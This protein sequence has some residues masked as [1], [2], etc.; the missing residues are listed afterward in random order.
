[1]PDAA[2][3]AA[4]LYELKS[5]QELV[6]RRIVGTIPPGAPFFEDFDLE[7]T[8]SKDIILNWRHQESDLVFGPI[9]SQTAQYVPSASFRCYYNLKIIFHI[10]S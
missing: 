2:N 9:N 5:R 3:L 10:L 4:V 7:P 6:Y 8:A 1:M